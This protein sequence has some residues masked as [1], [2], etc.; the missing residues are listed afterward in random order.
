[1]WIF[2]CLLCALGTV[3]T[4]IKISLLERKLLTLVLA[5]LTAILCIIS[6]PWATRINMQGLTSFLNHQDVL[7]N[8]CTLHVIESIAMLLVVAHL[9]KQHVDHKPVSLARM[10]VLLPSS[11]CLTGVF[12]LMVYLFNTITGH[13]YFLIGCVYVLGVFTVLAGGALIVRRLMTAWYARLETVLILSFVQLILAMFLPL[14]ARGL[15]VPTHGAH[16]H[17]RALPV[18]VLLALLF[19]AVAFAVRK[20]TNK[21]WG[22]RTK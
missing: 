19:A 9:M 14:V 17:I 6:I 1:M 12:V 20:I 8:L 10:V 15:T 3:L 21:I 5:C 11:A 22:D 4:L 16:Y 18:S 7:N 13:S 2:I